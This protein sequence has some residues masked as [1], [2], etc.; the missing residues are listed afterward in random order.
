MR[1]PRVHVCR[2]GATD[3]HVLACIALDFRSDFDSLEFSQDRA[4]ASDPDASNSQSTG[5]KVTRSGPDH[6]MYKWKNS[7]TDCPHF[8][9]S[10]LEVETSRPAFVLKLINYHYYLLFYLNL[11]IFYVS[12]N[13]QQDLQPYRFKRY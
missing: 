7:G 13:R 4:A 8:A 3:A 10:S 2:R 5:V 11:S 6:H 12:A 9:V 1:A